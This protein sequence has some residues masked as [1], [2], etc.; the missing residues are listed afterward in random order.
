MFSQFSYIC[1]ESTLY[2]AWNYVKSKGSAGG[3]DGVTIEEFNK[4]KYRQIMQIQEELKNGTWKPQPYLQISIP[5][6]KNPKEKRILG[7]AAVKDKV[8]QQAIRQIIEPRFE[9]L[10]LTNSY[11]YR[12]GKSALKAIRN[13]V[14][15]CGNEDYKYAIKL[16]IGNFFDE[17][18]HAILQKRLT[19]VGVE[20]EIVRLIMLSVKMGRVDASGK[21]NES[22]KGIPQGAVLSP[23]LANL[24]LHSFD[25][26]CV[27]KGLPYIRYGDD[28]LMLCKTEEQAVDIQEKA[29]TYLGS[30]LNLTLNT[31]IIA[32]ISAGFDFLGVTI[33][34]QEV[35]I[36]DEKRA[37]LE[38][39][40]LNMIIGLE[41]FIP[42]SQKDKQ[43]CWQKPLKEQKSSNPM[44][45]SGNYIYKLRC[46]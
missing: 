41:G 6:S 26:F 17:I 13:I 2:K 42:R 32:Q 29:E 12:H 9:K 46:I 40:I 22:T 37:E 39:S 5:K 18:D 25:Q 4:V 33:K 24:Y 23:L 16:D 8:I 28:S 34:G 21:W 45:Q 1:Q 35:F 44:L 43:N 27:S 10:F 30:K 36:K 14:R 38:N 20:D 15:L 11:A 31:P 7:M 3:I 19:A